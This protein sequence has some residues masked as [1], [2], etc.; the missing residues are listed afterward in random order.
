MKNSFATPTIL[1]LLLVACLTAASSVS[2]A[3]MLQAFEHSNRRAIYWD[4]LRLDQEPPRNMNISSGVHATAVVLP[5]NSRMNLFGQWTFS[6]IKYTDG[7]GDPNDFMGSPLVGIQLDGRGVNYWE[8][9]CRLPLG[10][11]GDDARSQGLAS[12]ASR[13]S[14]FFDEHFSF[15]GMAHIGSN[16][17]QTSTFW[18]LGM[19]VMVPVASDL[20]TEVIFDYGFSGVSD[21]GGVSAFGSLSGRYIPTRDG[22]IGDRTTHR[23][24]VGLGS[25]GKLFGV[26]FRVILPIDDNYFETVNFGYAFSASVYP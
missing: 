7:R 2:S 18:D 26:G 15:G 3:G 25:S 13:M 17:G 9:G 22:S 10:S 16:H 5:L 24:Q 8:F 1:A 11:G 20:E 14:S 4:F 23:L 12:D 19:E 21:L 6:A